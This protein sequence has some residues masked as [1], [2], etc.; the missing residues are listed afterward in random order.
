MTVLSARPC[1]PAP[2][3]PSEPQYPN[4]PEAREGDL[5]ARQ[6]ADWKRTFLENCMARRLAS[7]TV[8]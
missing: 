5:V 2:A 8:P 4:Q 6:G 3:A 1:L 7:K